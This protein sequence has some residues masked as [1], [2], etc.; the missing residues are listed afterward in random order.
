[1]QQEV[2]IVTG[3]R[4][5]VRIP[6]RQIIAFVGVSGS[7]K[8]S[9]IVVEYDLDVIARADL[10]IDVVFEGP[11]AKLVES[12]ASSTGE[13]LARYAGATAGPR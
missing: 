10:V 6:K 8:S 9:A 3:A 13:H 5:N 4:E 7:V 12:P 1:M 2:V 11:P